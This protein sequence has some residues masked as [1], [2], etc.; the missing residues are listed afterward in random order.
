MVFFFLFGTLFLLIACLVLIQWAAAVPFVL[1]GA[2]VFVVT[3]C[4]IDLATYATGK[5]VNVFYIPIGVELAI[6]AV[7]W[8]LLFFEIPERWTR[9]YYVHMYLNSH[10]WYTIL[11][12]SFLFEAQAI[13]FYTI[14]LN[15]G[16][17]VDDNLWWVIKNIYNVN[18]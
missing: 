17:T 7:G 1:I 15:S 8:V 12:I 11:L 14:Q 6:F 16:K 5:Q 2:L 3:T 18:N 4:I 9:N 13:I 10:I